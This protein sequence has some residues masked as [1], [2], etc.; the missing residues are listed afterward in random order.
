M[1]GLIMILAIPFVF[2]PIGIYIAS[3]GDW[4]EILKYYIVFIVIASIFGYIFLA[5]YLSKGSSLC[6]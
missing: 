3:D 5:V 4:K 2:M 1:I 6:M